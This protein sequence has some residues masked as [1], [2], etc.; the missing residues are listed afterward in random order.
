MVGTGT[1]RLESFIHPEQKLQNSIFKSVTDRFQMSYSAK[2]PGIR[3]LQSKS[4][5]RKKL[6]SHHMDNKNDLVNKNLYGIEN[7]ITC[8]ESKPKE[9]RQTRNKDFEIMCG[10]KVAF[11]ATSPRFHFNQVFAGQSLKFE[12]PGPGQYEETSTMR[13]H[14]INASRSQTRERKAVF[15]SQERRFK[16]KGLNSFYHAGATQPI[17]GP[18]SYITTDGSLMRKTFNMSM[19][20][21]SFA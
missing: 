5:E 9:V 20:N 13:P 11:D 2:N 10:K 15:S 3:I 19:E 4:G 14:S 12:V 17:V 18:G 16:Q 7:K 21:H 6:V 1:S 8:L